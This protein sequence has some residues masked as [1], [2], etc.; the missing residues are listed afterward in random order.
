MLAV[1]LIVFL[2]VFVRFFNCEIVSSLS[3]ISITNSTCISWDE[4]HYRWISCDSNSTSPATSH[5]A[6]IAGGIV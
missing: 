1:S 4:L 3:N 5:E 6:F 2:T